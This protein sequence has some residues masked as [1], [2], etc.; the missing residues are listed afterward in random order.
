MSDPYLGQL[1]LVGFNF[2]PVGWQI[3]AGQTLAISQW[4]ALF[5]LLGTYYGGN[6]TSNFQLPNLQ[7]NVA[8]LQNYVIGEPG[9]V[10]NVTL[11]ASSTPSHTHTPEAVARPAVETAPAGNAFAETTGSLPIYSTDTTLTNMSPAAIPV[12]GGNQPHNNMMPYLSM[13]WII[14]MSGV[15]PPRS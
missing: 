6:G 4:S 11:I 12:Y 15:F 7:G 2:A 1:A 3:A 9:G 13:N 5:S 14:A 8:G 10:Q